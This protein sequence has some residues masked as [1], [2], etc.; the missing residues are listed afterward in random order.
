MQH[1]P[2]LHQRL[3]GEG[4]RQL[5]VQFHGNSKVDIERAV[6]HVAMPGSGHAVEAK[7]SLEWPICMSISSQWAAATII[8][9]EASVMACLNT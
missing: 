7:A 3:Q 6:Y 4:T 2:G 9:R 5:T 1:H 8:A